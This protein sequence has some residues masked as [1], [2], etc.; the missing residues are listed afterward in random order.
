MEPSRHIKDE[1][2]LAQRRYER[3][4]E[5]ART[6]PAAVLSQDIGH[7]LGHVSVDGYG[8]LMSV[9]VDPDGLRFT[10]GRQLGEAVVRA[11]HQAEQRAQQI[12]SVESP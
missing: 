11:I 1:L 2:A 4:V 7:G 10:N 3:A 6:L 8:R 12:R 5:K 9:I